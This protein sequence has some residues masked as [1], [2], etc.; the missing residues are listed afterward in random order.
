MVKVTGPSYPEGKEMTVVNGEDL[1]VSNLIYGQ[2]QVKELN[3]TGYL[4][5]ISPAVMLTVEHKSGIVTV[6]NKLEKA[7]S[8]IVKNQK[9]E[10]RILTGDSANIV[11]Y[12]SVGICAMGMLVLVSRRNKRKRR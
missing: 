7:G 11:L 2:Y 3:T 6:T 9:K 12:S 5:T 1:I 8:S 10:E 4:V